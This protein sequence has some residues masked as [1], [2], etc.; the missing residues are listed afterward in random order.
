M[1]ADPASGPST[2]WVIR[3]AGDPARFASLVRAAVREAEP[4]AAISNLTTM[5]EQ[6]EIQTSVSRFRTWLLGLF[7]GLAML[8]ASVGIYGAMSYCTAQRT[9]EVGV[10]MALDA[11]R[12][13]ILGMIL[14]QGTALAAMG[15]GVGMMGAAALTHDFRF[16]VRRRRRRDFVSGH[17]RDSGRSVDRTAR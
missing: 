9:Q 6:I 5:G 14:R 17:T 12:S 11:H 16:T 1:Q 15:L 4:H 10:R 3:T 13:S 8:L 2:D 7:A